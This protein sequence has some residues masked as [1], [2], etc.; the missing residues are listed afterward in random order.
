[1]KVFLS[2]VNNSAS[3]RKAETAVKKH[4]GMLRTFRALSLGIAAYTDSRH[5]LNSA[6]RILSP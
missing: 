4:G 3:W 1:V 6:T 5:C 2:T